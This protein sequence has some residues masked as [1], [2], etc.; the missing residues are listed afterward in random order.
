MSTIDL[1]PVELELYHSRT[2]LSF[3]Q[4]VEFFSYI[5]FY[6]MHSLRGKALSLW[7]CYT[8]YC[9]T[10]CV[11]QCVLDNFFLNL[12]IFCEPTV[13]G[14]HLNI[15]NILI[16]TFKTKGASVQIK[17]C[18]LLRS[19][20]SCSMSNTMWQIKVHLWV[21]AINFTTMAIIFHGKCLKRL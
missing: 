12:N 11:L 9:I 6:F 7:A 10:V 13:A 18:L 17:S 21:I 15:G 8:H 14:L 1:N 3:F 2:I 4:A 5:L 20:Q 16:K 19:K